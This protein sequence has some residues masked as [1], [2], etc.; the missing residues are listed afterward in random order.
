[1]YEKFIEFNDLTYLYKS[2]R[3]D[4]VTRK[5]FREASLSI[6][7]I[8]KLKKFLKK[9]KDPLAIRSSGIFEDSLTQR[10]SGIYHTY[11]IP[12][13]D[14]KLEVRL[15]QLRTAIKMVY[16][17]VFSEA[18]YSYFEAVNHKI[19]EER[20]AVIIQKV[21]GK[22]LNE[23]FYPQF[24]GIAQSY[25]Y[26][27][28]SYLKPSEGIS[29]I[30][31]GLG[32][33]VLEGEKAFR[34]CPEHP[35]LNIL[36]PDEQ[37]NQTQT[38]FYAIDLSKSKIDLLQGE[39]AAIKKYHIEE[40]EKD[41]ML[42]KIASVWD[43]QNQR[44]KPGIYSAG[45]RIINFDYILKY[46]A[47]P[48]SDILKLVMETIE[49]AMGTPVEIEFSVALN[50]N[51]QKNPEFYILQI[52]PLVRNSVDFC[53]SLDCIDKKKL[54]LYSEK[55]M[56]NGEIKSIHDIICVFPENF[57]KAE[58][59]E[60]TEEIDKLNK[61][62]RESGKEYL[63]I[64]PG[65]WGTRDRWLGIPVSWVQ[66]SNARIIVEYNLED[67]RADPSLGSHFF[68]NVISMDVGYFSVPYNSKTNFINWNWLKQQKIEYQG[69]YFTHIRLEK[70]LTVKMDGTKSISLIEI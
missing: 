56:G 15:A 68:H 13:N 63:L 24:S 30:G 58:T 27:P 22:E 26:Y 44:I 40:A 42:G 39:S 52:K 55:A 59:V 1:E 29:V 64:G 60:M 25:N 36:S 46:D 43:Y 34:F 38:N 12:N 70:N 10:F 6:E 49:I 66:I 14:E 61:K 67:L 65:R 9:V 3:K 45:P 33:Y 69:K 20:M 11:L 18:A 7:L 47:F 4:E 41:G 8:R 54:L 19:E 51:E 50:E 31:V 57:N 17:S 53:I 2:T 5:C 35:E 23:K 62:M 21:V 48:L 37:L 32:E 16:A 28:V